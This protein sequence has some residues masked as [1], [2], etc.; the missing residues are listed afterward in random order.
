MVFTSKLWN[1]LFIE[2]QKIEDFENR[3]GDG[4]DINKYVV[5]WAQP[6]Y[7]KEQILF[8][9]LDPRMVKQPHVKEHQEEEV[10]LVL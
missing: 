4:F 8:F 9:T 5:D 6:G 1:T 3:W 7:T 2:G 10:C